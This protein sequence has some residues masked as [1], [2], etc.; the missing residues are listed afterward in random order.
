MLRSSGLRLMITSFVLL[1]ILSVYI[2][3]LHASNPEI[4]NN[5][6]ANSLEFVSGENISQDMFGNMHINLD[7]FENVG[8][9]Q[10]CS[11]TFKNNNNYTA[12]SNIH[13]DVPNEYVSVQ[14]D[15]NMNIKPGE[16]QTYRFSFTLID[17]P[18]EQT[19]FSIDMSINTEYLP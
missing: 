13:I 5:T 6:K 9:T 12:Y 10:Y 7:S 3:F 8:D 17:T 16:T 2:V 19:T 14:Y 15:K 4:H 18:T 1:T 11:V